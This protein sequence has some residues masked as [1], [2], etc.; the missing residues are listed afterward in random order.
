MMKYAVVILA[1]LIQGIQS[2][3][4]TRTNT[5]KDFCAKSCDPSQN[6]PCK[7]NRLCLCDGDCGFSCV[8]ADRRCPTPEIPANGRVRGKNTTFGS[9]IKY[10][11]S[12]SYKLQGPKTRTCRGNGKWDG[13]T[14]I[15]KGRCTDPGD[16][17]NGRKQGNNYESGQKV[18]YTCSKGFTMQGSSTLTCKSTGSWNRP[19]PKCVCKRTNTKAFRYCKK[20]CNPKRRDCKKNNEC[21]CDGDCGYSC[22]AKGLTCSRPV[23]IDNGNRQYTS[24]KFWSSVKY[25]CNKPYTLVGAQT[26]TCRGIRSWDGIEPV[27]KII[28]QD[29]GDITHGSKQSFRRSYDDAYATV[30]DRVEYNCYPGYKME[31]SQLVCD[32]NGKC[33]KQLVCNKNGKWS[34]SKPNCTVP[35][36]GPPQLPPN[37]ELWRSQSGKT[38][39]NYKERVAIKCKSGYFI[40]GF[41]YRTCDSSG[42]TGPKFSCSPKSCGHPGSISNGELKSYVFTFKSKVHYHCNHGYKLVGDKFRQCQANEQWSGRQPKCELIDC[43]VLPTPVKASKVLETHTRVD[44]TVRFKCTEKGYEISGSEIR[45]CLNTGLWS[46]TKTKCTIISCADRGSP[47]NGKKVNAKNKYNYGDTLKFEC[48]DNYTLEGNRQIKCEETKDWSGALPYC[49]AP[50]A[51]PGVPYQGNRNSQDFRHGRT[52]RFTCRTDYVMEGVAAITCR[53]GKW[54]NKKPSCKAPC[55]DPGS[56]TNGRIIGDDFSH[57]QSVRYTCNTGFELKGDQLL[58]CSDGRWSGNKPLCKVIR[59]RDPGSPINGKQVNTKNHYNYEDTLEFACNDNYTLEGYRQIKCKETKHWS[60]DVPSCRAPCL[61]PG[62]PGNGSMSGDDFRHDGTVRYTC[63]PG[64]GLEGDQLLKCSDGRWIGNKPQCKVCRIGNALGM[65]SRIIPDS[66]IRASSEREGHPAYHARLGGKSFWCSKRENSHNYLTIDFPRK[67]KI[68]SVSVN[69]TEF[70]QS[71]EIYLSTQMLNKWIDV[72]KVINLKKGFLKIVPSEPFIGKNVKIQVMYN[73]RGMGVKTSV[74]LRAEVYGCE[75]PQG[76]LLTGS[77]VI[78]KANGRYLKTHVKNVYRSRNQFRV[79]DHRGVLSTRDA[80]LD[81]TP[82]PAKLTPNTLVL[83]KNIGSGSFQ[84]G[85]IEQKDGAKY[86][87]KTKGVIWA[88]EL[89]DVRL[90]KSP[91]FCLL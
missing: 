71:D 85:I 87:I 65:S 44:G 33:F 13:E 63:K 11:C 37:S 55:L 25:T 38:S 61:Y 10:R 7:G 29:P 12:S 36:C 91:E 23:Q 66:F 24:T 86:L 46:G 9:V 19:K 35:T 51:D 73:G 72:D 26:R 69:V 6:S 68:T 67:Y 74:C 82:D 32:K 56:P 80:V 43:G 21:V 20:S 31:G 30:G 3:N 48:N 15:C 17:S 50:C 34:G 28:C 89:N 78:V 77:A 41:G 81:E 18:K 2:K 47:I 42:W 22:V 83:G 79:I 60:E 58:K 39:Y 62:I 88:S 70:Y 57:S 5:K 75:I 27:C 84:K 8:K 45:K 16:I 53:E 40:R 4:C 1:V 90:A 52:V 54:S 14:P 49:R 59:C 76:C 64:F